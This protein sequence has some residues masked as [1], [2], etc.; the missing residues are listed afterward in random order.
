VKE[1][2][3]LGDKF[4]LTFSVTKE[5]LAQFDG[6]VVHPFY[7]TF[8]LGR[9]AEWTCRQFILQMK[10]KHEEGIGT[11]LNIKH[12]S[13]A[14]LGETVRIEAIIKLLEGKRIDCDW[15]AWVGDR[16]IAEGE[17]GQL[18]LT[19]EKIQEITPRNYSSE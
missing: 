8:S 9:D 12:K 6:K 17:Q 7:S 15:K 18:I 19:K 5:D 16:L 10:E 14:L 2:Y 3:H 11:F 13:P 4:E 1:V